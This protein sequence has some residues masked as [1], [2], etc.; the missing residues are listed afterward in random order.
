MQELQQQVGSRVIRGPDWKWGKQ[1]GGEG[2]TGTVRNFESREEVV[3]V[4][5]NGTAANYRCFGQYDLR[6]LDSGP[7]GQRHLGSMC[8]MCHQQPI[9]GHRWK[10]AD[11]ANYDLCTWCYHGDKHNIRHRFYRITSATSMSD[12]QLMESRK[13]SKKISVRGIF[14]GARVVRGVDWQWEDQDGGGS[15]SSNL[16]GQNN[17]TANNNRRG[18]VHDIQDWS[19][20]SARSAAYVC[21]ENAGGTK[22]LYRVGFEGMCDLK[23]VQDSKA[24]CTVYRDH[25]P[26][27]GQLMPGSLPDAGVNLLQQQQQLQIG[28]QVTVDLELDVVQSLQQGHGGWTDGMFECLRRTPGSLP[29]EANYLAIGSV[30]GVDED[31]D[32]VVSYPSGNRWTFNAAVLTKVSSGNL[33]SSGA[34]ASSDAASLTPATITVGSTVIVDA[35]LQRVK[36]LQRGHG[37]WAD[38]MLMTL[39]KVGVVQQVYDDGDLKVAVCDTSWTYNPRCLT[40]ASRSSRPIPGAV[41]AGGYYYYGG[42]GAVGESRGTGDD[43]QLRDL[44]YAREGDCDEAS[45][46]EKMKLAKIGPSDT[47]RLGEQLVRSAANGDMQTC[48]HILELFTKRLD[49][50]QQEQDNL[51]SIGIETNSMN[52]N[53]SSS[54]PNHSNNNNGA[55]SSNNN[56]NGINQ[57]SVSSSLDPPPTNTGASIT[58]PSVSLTQDS[59]VVTP[60][61]GTLQTADRDQPT[62][63]NNSL[64]DYVYNGHCALQAAAQNGHVRLCKMLIAEYGAN[65]EFEDKDGDRAVHHAAFGDEPQVIELLVGEYDA[66][67]NARNKR[68]QTALHIAVNRGH[69]SVVRT[70]LRLNCL[71]SLQDTDGDTPLHDA[72]SKKRDDIVAMLLDGNGTGSGGADIMLAN[73]NGFNALHHAALRGNP[74]AMSVLLSKL[75]RRH[76]WM[77][78]EKKDDGYTALHLAALNN[79]TQV[80]QLLVEVGRADTDARNVNLQTPLHL[81][82]ERQHVQIVRLLVRSGADPNVPDKD[83][84]TALHEALR[85]HTLQQIRQMQQTIGTT[86]PATASAN[87]CQTD[88]KLFSGGSMLMKTGTDKKTS[89]SLPAS[90]AS[91]AVGNSSSSSISSSITCFLAGTGRADLYQRNKKGQTPLDLCPDPALRRALI[92]CAKDRQQ[93]DTVTNVGASAIPLQ[94]LP[95]STSAVA[96]NKIDSPPL[97]PSHCC[98]NTSAPNNNN[99]NLTSNTTPRH[100][101]AHQNLVQKQSNISAPQ[102][103]CQPSPYSDSESNATDTQSFAS[104]AQQKPINNA[105]ANKT[106]AC[107]CYC[108]EGAKPNP[109]AGKPDDIECSSTANRSLKPTVGEKI[110]NGDISADPPLFQ[111]GPVDPLS[112]DEIINSQSNTLSADTAAVPRQCCVT[113]ACTCSSAVSRSVTPSVPSPNYCSLSAPA[114]VTA[115]P[116]IKNH[117][118]HHHHHHH[119][120]HLDNLKTSSYNTNAAAGRIGERHSQDYSPPSYGAGDSIMNNGGLARPTKPCGSLDKSDNLDVVVVKLQQQLQ[121]IKE[122]TMCPVCLDRLKNMIFMCGHGTC[123][124]CGDRMHE[125]PICRKPVT[126]TILLY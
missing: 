55:S 115:N 22:N 54:V 86:G 73:N 18:K 5:D 33:A 116:A 111:S 103:A 64:V 19:A 79:H 66:D 90:G 50:S 32:I 119:V 117:H 104:S 1:D 85:H 70:L 99:I 77:V 122:Q 96:F 113:C 106:R 52:N 21:W 72:I 6:V 38:A 105:V 16:S 51:T 37:E 35:D 63:T 3:V 26:L 14:A 114:A 7:T 23:T 100:S 4:W 10:C 67:I 2:H 97:S 25:L 102:N 107:C 45:L 28:D 17:A 92:K 87:C 91:N 95:P 20:A 62:V 29:G 57:L 82:V 65:V 98:S 84:D 30:V 69:A 48:R 83:G 126:K 60:L 11:C 80:A 74:S 8:D 112:A 39:G 9:V 94:S 108:G 15:C 34:A 13:K 53:F 78:D 41:A 40:L 93:Q 42:V 118:L 47:V 46:I 110:D 76:W 56:S 88:N 125:C 124:M 101:V 36:T 59:A 71:P 75:P 121:D 44:L 68:R 81:A 109:T 27:L 120:P 123:Q 43:Q 89:V 58:A 31:H 24:S 61:D 49:A 12:R